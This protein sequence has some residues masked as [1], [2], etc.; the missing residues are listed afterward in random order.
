MTGDPL[1]ELVPQ[2]C[3]TS[4]RDNYTYSR[5]FLLI[6]NF[7]VMAF[8]PFLLLIIFNS[9]TFKIIRQSSLTSGRRSSRQRRDLRIASMFISIV[10]I[11]FI[12]NMPRMFLNTLDVRMSSNYFLISVY[13]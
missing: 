8:I 10:I 1:S 2:V 13:F 9:L 12:C 3:S 7:V 5:D 4:L 6:A 11:F